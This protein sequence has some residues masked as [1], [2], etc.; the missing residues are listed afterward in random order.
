MLDTNADERI[1]GQS[2]QRLSRYFALLMAVI[3]V[4]LGIFLFL[5]PD[6]MLTL[7][8][9]ARQIVGGLFVLYGLI[10]FVRTIRQF[11]PRSRHDSLSH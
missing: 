4:A 7:S 5:A 6:G 11:S 3:Y 2:S 9:T 8:R 10:R 1:G